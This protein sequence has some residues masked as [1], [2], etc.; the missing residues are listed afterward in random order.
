MKRVLIVGLLILLSGTADAAEVLP[1]TMRGL[2]AFEPTDCAN[3]DSDGLLT[4]DAKTV[5]FYASGYE[6]K[7]VVRR[8]DGSMRVSGLVSNEGEEGRSRGAITLKLI[9]RDKLHVGN[10][11]GHTYHRCPEPLKSENQNG[12]A[13]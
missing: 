7:R 8:P 4:I 13:Q 12:K 9:A 6:I 10:G 2:W 5:L 11:D 1:K 3:P